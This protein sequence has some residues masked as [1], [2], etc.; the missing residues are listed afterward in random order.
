MKGTHKDI[1]YYKKEEKNIDL[2]GFSLKQVTRKKVFIINEPTIFSCFSYPTIMHN[3]PP[4]D[5]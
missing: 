2:L 3:T 1:M 5:I 4:A